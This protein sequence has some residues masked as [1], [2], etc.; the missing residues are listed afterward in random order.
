MEGA[1]LL[2]VAAGQ[3]SSVFYVAFVLLFTVVDLV[4]MSFASPTRMYM[5]ID[6]PCES[7]I[8]VVEN[9]R[10]FLTADNTAMRFESVCVYLDHNGSGAPTDI[11]LGEFNADPRTTPSRRPQR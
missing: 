10:Q 7:V 6:T 4:L 11:E 8:A 2:L 3:L 9:L 1:Q 5:H